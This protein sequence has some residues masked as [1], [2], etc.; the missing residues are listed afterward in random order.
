MVRYPQSQR[1]V[2][3]GVLYIALI[4]ISLAMLVPL[5]WTLSTSLTALDQLNVW[6]PRAIP[7]PIAWDNYVKVF[8]LVPIGHYFLNTL[9]IVVATEVGSLVT[10]SFVAYGFARTTFPGKNILFGLLLST[11]MMP[12]IVR[13][14]PLF[15]IYSKIGWINTFLPLTVPAL[16][17]RN[18]F[19]IFLLHQFFK[20]IPT[21]LSDA[22]RIDGC[23]DVRI[24][25]RIM[26]PLSKPVLAAVSIFA[27]QAAWDDFLGQLVYMGGDPN[28]YTL[29]VGLYNLRVAPGEAPLIPYL[30]AMSA[31]LIVP[32]LAVFALGQ[33]YFI[34]GVALSGLKG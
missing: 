10:C 14:M 18:A 24:W 3:R 7:Q 23:N 30:M 27:F 21:E 33:R 9:V 34:Q 2:G 22:A 16:L 26:L 31:M 17:G 4:I 12:Y 15:I 1:V 32:V 25:W 13:L 6:P 28:L 8:Q 20:G 19:F 29:A 5:G 11:I